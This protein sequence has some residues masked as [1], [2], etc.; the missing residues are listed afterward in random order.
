[1]NRRIYV[2]SLLGALSLVADS[3]MFSFGA[4]YFN[5]D[6][7]YQSLEWTQWAAGLVIGWPLLVFER[8]FLSVPRVASPQSRTPLVFLGLL[9]LDVLIYSLPIYVLLRWRQRDR[10]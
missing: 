6:R 7:Q 2:W 9:V 5:A 8:M 4:A 1:M 10:A 3:L